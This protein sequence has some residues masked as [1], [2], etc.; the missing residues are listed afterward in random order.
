MNLWPFAR[1]PDA[2][3]PAPVARVEPRLI[4][5]P[6]RA[7]MRIGYAALARA[8]TKPTPPKVKWTVAAPMPGVVP[9]GTP[10]LAQDDALAG[11]YGFLERQPLEFGAQWLGYPILA[12][13]AQR[14]EYRRISETLAKEMTR[15]WIK[16][17]STSDA[18]KSAKLTA[19]DA[20]LKRFRVQQHF[21]RLTELDGFFGSAK[22]YIDTGAGDDRDELATPL[23]RNR[24]KIRKGG[25][26]RF[27]VIEPMWTY[28][29]EY[30]ASDPLHPGYY[31]PRSWFVQG[32][33]LHG[34]R[35]L[36]FVSREVPDLL[37]PAYS[38]GGLSMTQIAMPYVEN[39]LRTRQSVSDL[40]HSFSV[41]GLKTNMQATLAEADLDGATGEDEMAKRMALFGAYKDN[42]NTMLIDKETEE[43]F[44]VIT[45]L[46]TLDHLQA[47]SQEQMSSVAGIPLVILLGITPS[48]LNAST[49]GEIKA[50]GQWI[51]A[52][53]EQLY[54]DNLQVALEV[55]QLSE[56]GEV[57]PDITFTYEP[58][59]DVDESQKS[60]IRKTDADAAVAYINAGVISPRDERSRLAKEETGIYV[61][62]DVDDLPDPPG[63]MGGEEPMDGDP[64]AVPG[65]EPP[66]PT[67]QSD[68][69]P[70][71]DQRVV[72]FRRAVND[73]APALDAEFKESDHTRDDS[74]KFGSGGGGASKSGEEH[75][76]SSEGSQFSSKDEPNVFP[77]DKIK[78]VLEDLSRKYPPL[79][80]IKIRTHEGGDA[81]AMNGG[82]GLDG[83]HSVSFDTALWSD[84]KFLA[85]NAKEWDGL[86]VDSSPEGT[87]THE[88]GHV[89]YQIIEARIGLKAAGKIVEDAFG[90]SDWRGGASI[91]AEAASPYGQED[92][93]EAT[94]E[95]FVSHHLNRAS[96]PGP[97]ADVA[98]KT[99]HA[100]W[101]KLLAAYAEAK[102]T[103]STKKQAQDKEF[104]ESDHPRGQPENA[105]QFGPGGGGGAPAKKPAAKAVQAKAPPGS[106]QYN[107]ATTANAKGRTSGQTNAPSGQTNA[108][109]TSRAGMLPTK[110]E[111]KTRVQANGQPLPPHIEAL[112]VPPGWA[113]VK[114]N[115][116]PNA[117]LLATGK[118]AKGRPTAVYSEEYSGEQAAKKFARVKAMAE[119]FD[120]V[121]DKN[122]AAKADPKTQNVADCLDLVMKMGVRPG[123][124]KDTGAKVKAYGAT[125]IEGR[126]VVD[127][128][129]GVW[130]RFT[131][132][133]GVNLNL[134]VMDDDLAKNLLE[135]AREA[136]PDRPL[137]G[138]NERELLKHL[139]G[140]A[141]AAFKTKDLRTNLG[142]ATAMRMVQAQPPP[143]DE[144]AY[145]AAVH[146]VAKAVSAKLGNTPAI[147]LQSYIAPEI[148]SPWQIR[149]A[150]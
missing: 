3:D 12:D 9:A 5:A 50:W 118:D 140:I 103:R 22:L 130:L 14:P 101:D 105:G 27:R 4:P 28:P 91:G 6:A 121:V 82:K 109:P 52:N 113:D 107:P 57:D 93:R 47:Q 7:G 111:G 84:P 141:G 25:L 146:E 123:S 65:A 36:T 126:H 55:V 46:G 83:R 51:S 86:V 149:K 76:V 72:P 137:F 49:D 108:S 39:W 77:E 106:P 75:A 2:P 95:A 132:K 104:S 119:R 138:V 150:A 71:G 59:G 128:Q 68:D 15:K 38:F 43:F 54:T 73:R 144:K 26:K 70:P 102:P 37:K 32:K 69:L 94:A 8:N 44:N 97:L 143:A 116:D 30:N 66:D 58:L 10:E 127:D 74:G 120:Q 20:A 112:K 145:K 117:A 29:A 56:F 148:F 33:R 64:N 142:T 115:P 134:P 19:L 1:R 90:V 81:L 85:K 34:S 23:A 62:L 122:E 88:I 31:A 110:I 63:T 133:K 125:T 67:Q 139:K 78:S 96:H 100:L 24:S 147:A 80:D 18:D 98:I 61:G 42:K 131:G 41:S 17:R 129:G 60:T 99:S 53:Q 124:N 21:R 87:I 45:P 40:I 114:F 13:L 89:L 16:L 135:R 79:G 11:L 92:L 35:L 136:G 48:G